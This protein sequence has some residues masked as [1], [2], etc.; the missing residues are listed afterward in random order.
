MKRILITIL[1]FFLLFCQKTN[2]QKWVDTLY[3]IQQT[4]NIE[5][6]VQADYAGNMRSLTMN[7]CV[8]TNDNP[9]ICGR[10]LLIAIHGGAFLAGSKDAD[11]PPAM[12]RDFAKR[13]YTTASIN[14]RL[15]MFQTNALINCNIS[16]LGIGWNC[17]NMQDTAEWYR[18]AYRGMQDAKSAIRYLIN[19]ANTYQIDPRNV[20]VVG[21]SAGGFIAL[22]TT[23]LDEAIEKPIECGVLPNVIPPNA[24]YENQCIQTPG[25]DTSIA[26]M[27][28]SRPDLGSIDGT[29]NPTTIPYTIKGVGNFFG[30]IMQDV[31]T[32]H[33]YSQAPALYMF[34]QFNDLVVPYNYNNILQGIT[35]CYT[36]FPANCQW[37]INRP[38][39]YGSR[40]IKNMIDG[41]NGAII[42]LPN[43]LFDTTANNGD[44]LA[45]AN[46]PAHSIDNYWLRTT[47][48]ASFFA[49]TIDTNDVCT[50]TSTSHISKNNSIKIY[51]NPI[52]QNQCMIHSEFKIEKVTLIDIQGK[53]VFSSNE[54][55][56]LYTFPTLPSGIYFLKVNTTKEVNMIKVIIK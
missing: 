55:K 7:I 15:G 17:L 44:C 52:I 3:Q 50:P 43:I 22:A 34:H 37:I 10:P 40:G 1:T 27:N 32:Q 39:S 8:P 31:F 48:M 21:E 47:N 36:Q 28:L 30:G 42:P 5:Y 16:L 45:Q 51:P 9:P 38:K 23:F 41:L 2:A 53:I 26:L 29:G 14:Y 54:N 35:Y 46:N 19:N 11:L 13:G 33:S 56:T 12:I 20:Y 24:I 25:F 18:A 49:N 6:D 4:N